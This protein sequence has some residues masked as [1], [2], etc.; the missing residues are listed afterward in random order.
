[1]N[2]EHKPKN[3]EIVVSDVRKKALFW[4]RT[5]SKDMKITMVHNP[6]VNKTDNLEFEL[7]S[8]SSIQVERMFKNWLGWEINVK[9]VWKLNPE[10]DEH[11]RFRKGK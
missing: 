3:I 8:R 1:M 7:I 9:S 2:T 5:L 11:P 4:W 10:Q 6:N